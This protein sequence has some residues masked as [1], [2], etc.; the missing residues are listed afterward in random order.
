MHQT[1]KDLSLKEKIRITFHNIFSLSHALYSICFLGILISCIFLSFN[2]IQGLGDVV[3]FIITSFALTFLIY[4]FIGRIPQLENILFSEERK[5]QVKKIV[6]FL[7]IFTLSAVII[8]LYFFLGSS[9]QIPIQFLGWDFIL[10]SFFIILYFGWNLIQIFFLKNGFE[11]IAMNANEKLIANDYGSKK[12]D[13]FAMIFLIVALIIPIVIQLGTYFG[14]LYF[15]EPQSPTDSLEPLYWF[16][17]WNIAVFIIIALTS[18]RLIYLFIRSKKN[19]TPNVFS[20]LFYILIWLV[21]WFR[22]FSFINSFRSVSFA[23]G[24]DI[25]RALIDVM[26]MIFTAFMVL[27]SLGKK[28]YKFKIFNQNNIAFFLFAFTLIY[29]EGQIIMITGAGS[30]P[31]TYTNRSQINLL[32]NFLVLLITLIFYWWYSEYILERKGFIYRQKF[33]QSEVISI[34]SDFKEYLINSGALSSDK[35]S[36]R[37]FQNYLQSKNLDIEKMEIKGNQAS[38]SIEKSQEDHNKS[39]DDDDLPSQDDNYS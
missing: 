19:N 27:T 10:P 39:P 22:S 28:I 17:G 30:I 11:N 20:P 14:F 21:I 2:P 24:I 34:V 38:K 18:Y 4:L 29:I 25:F 6:F 5:D 13:L 36:E 1:Y 8:M 3:L 33:N 31:G 16:N 35:I 32:N 37:E 12:S 7:F 15:F 26:L 23:L 9:S